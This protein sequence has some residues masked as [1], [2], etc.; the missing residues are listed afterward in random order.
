[1]IK[2]VSLQATLALGGGRSGLGPVRRF[3]ALPVNESKDIR[4]EIADR[5]YL[6]P[7]VRADKA[8]YLEHFADPGDCPQ[9]VG[10]SVPLHR[11][12]RR[13]VARPLRAVR[14]LANDEFRSPRAIRRPHWCHRRRRTLSPAAIVQSSGTGWRNLIAGAVLCLASS[15][16]SATTHFKAPNSSA[17]CYA[18]L[19]NLASHRALE[20]AGF[21]REGLLRHHHLKQ[22]IYLDAIIYGRISDSN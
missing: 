13:L 11:G 2:T 18:V 9:P 6:S 8:A 5:F 19:L 16:H 7:I 4:L 14:R 20:K 21:Q 3:R 12:G 22:G 1:M 10:H 15:A 17:F